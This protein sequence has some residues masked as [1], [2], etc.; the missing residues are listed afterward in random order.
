[1]RRAAAVAHALAAALLVASTL[2]AAATPDAAPAPAPRDAVS[3]GAAPTAPAAPPAPT[4]IAGQPPALELRILTFNAEH[5]MSD[6]RFERW[7]AFCEPRGWHDPDAP[8]PFEDARPAELNFCDAL[9]GTDGRGKRLFKPLRTAADLADKRQQIR[10]LITSAKPDFVL[11]QE[12]SDASAAAALLGPEF[13]VLSSAELW[14][15]HRISQN[16]AIGWRES[17]PLHVGKVEL[18]ASIAKSGADGR[19]TR[20][21]IAVEVELDGGRR[22]AILN[23][24]LKAG[25]RMGRLD[26]A[27]SRDPERAERREAACSVF[28]AQVPAIEAWADAR[29]EAGAG[30]VI[31]GDFN[32]DLMRELRDKLPARN[33]DGDPG[34]PVDDPRKIVGL[35]PE[36]S[37]EEPRAAWFA[38]ARPGPYPKRAE[39]HRAIDGF[40][41]SRNLQAWTDTPLTKLRA[42][43]IPFAE[44]LSLDRV[45]PSDHCPHLLELRLTH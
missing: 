44:P 15:D 16:V 18:V 10:Q 7:R 12:V 41:L 37:D 22:L 30:V 27:P 8:V 11:L 29:L 14:R 28:Q 19:L 20:P 34:R 36:I 6:E 42:Q 35:L 25:C 45:R 31:A 2:A 43:P 17:L 5:L 39:C 3:H 32:R 4:V 21:G 26:E 23:L 40:L 13:R 38:I 24:H 9:D 1:M 33:D